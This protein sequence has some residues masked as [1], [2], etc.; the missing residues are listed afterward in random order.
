MQLCDVSP[1]EKEAQFICGITRK[2][3][4]V[5]NAY[6]AL[7]VILAMAAVAGAFLYF[8]GD[9][10]NG[11]TKW[12]G[13][14]CWFWV[15]VAWSFGEVASQA[16][17]NWKRAGLL[18][19]MLSPGHWGNVRIR[20]TCACDAGCSKWSCF[21][22]DF[23]LSLDR[24]PEAALYVDG[25]PVLHTRSLRLTAREVARLKSRRL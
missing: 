3:V 17:K 25:H 13:L 12:A 1:V 7:G 11:W 5:W 22:T 8:H 14:T 20:T 6:L 9:L 21:R 19:E 24:E 10:R 15:L 18:A 2:Q 4:R 16:R 23:V